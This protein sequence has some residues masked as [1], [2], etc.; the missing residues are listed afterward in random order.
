MALPTLTPEQRNQALA[1]AAQARKV[2]STVLAGLKTGQLSLA[3]VLAKAD[4]DE[5]IKKTKVTVLVK[6]LPGIGPV[7]A[8]QLME[9]AEIAKSR[10]VG[11]L[12]TKQRKLLLAA[13]G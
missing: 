3:E 12:G 13:V 6:A 9:Q 5:I 10:R 1:K 11:G 8:A 7:R 2:R 4:T